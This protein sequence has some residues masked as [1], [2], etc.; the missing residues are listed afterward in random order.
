MTMDKK[1]IDLRKAAAGYGRVKRRTRQHPQTLH[2]IKRAAIREAVAA[3]GGNREK[4]AKRLGIGIA[5]LY[6]YLRTDK[7]LAK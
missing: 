2:E 6:R 4:A 3:F 7:N 5:T 1:E